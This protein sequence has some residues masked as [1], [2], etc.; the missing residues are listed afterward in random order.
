MKTEDIILPEKKER[1]LLPQDFNVTTWEAVKPYYDDLLERNITSAADLQRWFQDR[2]ELEAVLSENLAWRYIKMTCDTTDDRLRESYT[3]FITQIEPKIAPVSNELNKKAL[4]SPYLS[5]LKNKEGYP[6]L[7][8]ELEKDAKIFRE[9][10]IPLKT[11]EQNEAQNFGKI[12]GAMNVKIDGKE[13]TLQQAANLLQSTDREVRKKAYHKITQR[14]LEDKDPLNA[15]FTKL[16]RL[17]NQIGKNADFANYRDYMFTAMGRFD[18]TPQDCFDFHEAVEKEIVPMLDELTATRK[19]KLEVKHLR[20][21]DKAVD[22]EGRSPLKPFATGKELTKKT[23]E[24]FGRLDPYLGERIAIMREMGHLDLESRKGKAPGG[25]NYPL[26]ETGV[27]FIFMNATSNLRDMVTMMHEGGHAVHSFLTRELELTNF[28]HTPSEVAELASMSMELISMD[29]WHLFFTEE[30]DLKRAKREHLQQIIETLP[31]VATIDKFQHWV[32]E[33]PEHTLEQRISHWNQIFDAF[34]DNI[35]DWSDLEKEKS[36]LWQK[37]LH[38][39]E[40][41]FYYIEYGFAQLGAIAVW[42]NYRDDPQKGL[43]G[44]KNALQLGYTKTI[45]E[46]YEAANIKFDFSTDYIRSLMQFVRSE[47]DAI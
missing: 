40:V 10:N 41:P 13:M 22:P 45:P 31:W 15:L 35:T 20:P 16:I 34:S 11:E 28:Q 7:I 25:Y 9:E 29:H 27:P 4:D 32:Y 44:Y 21:W 38:L 47:L 1:Q 43:E 33:N 23:I 14:R 8:R 6:I 42:K 5:E 26:S 39:Y 30:E 24:A 17:R 36:Y 37:Q 2:S 3:E 12:S 19:L 18:Y 46:V